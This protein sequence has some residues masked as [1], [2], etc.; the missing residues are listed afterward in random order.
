MFLCLISLTVKPG[1]STPA[2]KEDPPKTAPLSEPRPEPT[3][4]IREIIKQYN[5]RPQPE[6]KPFEPSRSVSISL[7]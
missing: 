6:P 4:N 7:S 1:P 5:S 3:S 2:K